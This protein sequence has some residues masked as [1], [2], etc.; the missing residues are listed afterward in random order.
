AARNSLRFDTLLPY[1]T[2]TAPTPPGPQAAYTHA[3]LGMHLH[4]VAAVWLLGDRPASVRAVAALH[5]LLVVLALLL[6]TRALWSETHAL[7]AAAVYTLLPINGIYVNMVNH[8]TGFQLWTLVLLACYVRLR[9]NRT[10]GWLVGMLVAAVMALQWDWP[11]YYVLPLV[12]LH[13]SLETLLH[14][15]RDSAHGQRWQR[16]GWLAGLLLIVMLSLVG[17]WQLSRVGA[18]HEEL[19]E[20]FRH[21]Q[22][23]DPETFARTLREVPSLLFGWPILALC[24]LWLLDLL[25]RCYLRRA[26]ARDLL[27]LI[28]LVAA[29]THFLLFK[30]SAWQ[31]EYWLWPA[32]PCV[33]LAAAEV[34]VRVAESLPRFAARPV[35]RAAQLL[36]LCAP[37]LVLAR[38]SAQLV[39]RARQT[40]G[41]LWFFAPV[42][43]AVPE[44]FDS[45]LS[46]Q[47][48]A[49]QV[50]RWT[51]RSTGVLMHTSLDRFAPESRFTAALDRAVQGVGAGLY[52]PT[53][54]GVD[55][56]VAVGSATELSLPQLF[57][58][59]GPFA[60]TLYDAYFII[61]MRR[62]D[63]AL[64][65]VELA[66]AKPTWPWRA[67]S[68]SFE[69]PRRP[70]RDLPRE[71]SLRAQRAAHRA[72]TS[73]AH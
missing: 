59:A 58:L 43:A 29:I 49:G 4:N 42:R 69:P 62:P 67:L 30:Q 2:H 37:L 54:P 19:T 45:G 32:L 64:E 1:Q 21:R 22:D 44:T 56:W 55:G 9:E 3:P 20:T 57:D 26:A 10:R 50:R 72:G 70:M 25:R 16:L 27:P 36:V 52:T 41:S 53:V 6:V 24:A 60:L 40:G 31:H 34:S 17:Q 46:E 38:H 68:W 63:G 18:G 66:P 47:R 51:T 28:F 12:L 8:S 15:R 65:V 13:L 61:D 73:V 39:P 14:W 5:G 71:A 23:L 48:L 11:A 35:R 7:I 33:A